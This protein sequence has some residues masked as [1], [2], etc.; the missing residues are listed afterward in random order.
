MTEVPARLAEIAGRVEARIDEVLAAELDRWRRVDA[1]LEAP[2]TALRN[3]V[4]AGGKRLRPAFCH[5][6]YVGAGG[7]PT[8]PIVTDAG[9]ALELLHT[10]ALIHDDIMDGSS[11]RRGLDATHV[12]FQQRH[13]EADWRGEARRF[14]EGV[15]ILVGDLAFVYADLLLRDAP[16]AALDVFTEL[17][18]EVNIGQYL[19]LIG[20]ARRDASVESARRI[21]IYKSGRYTT[22]RPLQLGAALAGRLDD[23]ADPLTAFGSPLGEAFQLRDDLLG[24][25]GDSAVTGKPVGE[26]LREGK[27]TALYALAAAEADGAAAKLLAARFGSPDLSAEEIAR[28]QEVLEST[29][30]R[31]KV[32]ARIGQLVDQSLYALAETPLTDEARREL[33]ALAAFV[34]GRDR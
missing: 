19:D 23:L 22:E 17:R 33:A 30:A 13:V 9:A 26:D 5:W 3:L 20:T 2:L 25:F 14:G 28:L 34:A 7:D 27:P 21:C 11:T 8:A 32:E 4:L 15:A 1:D 31:D 29:G 16:A 10:F 18:L 24:V 6:A 12:V